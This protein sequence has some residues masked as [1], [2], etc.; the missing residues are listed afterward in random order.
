MN[1]SLSIGDLKLS[2]SARVRDVGGDRDIQQR[3]SMLGIRWGTDIR[4][5]HGP[6][7]RGA[8][9]RVGGARIAL[10]WGAIW[11]IELVLPEADSRNTGE[12][13]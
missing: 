12:P 5:V 8:V 4:V 6:G 10:D 1:P 11:R 9:L 13:T 3:M 7:K 2:G